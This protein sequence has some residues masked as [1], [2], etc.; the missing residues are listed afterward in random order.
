ML[1]LNNCNKDSSALQ[2]YQYEQGNVIQLNESELD[3]PEISNLLN[4]LLENTSEYMRLYMDEGRFESLKREEQSAEF[5]FQNEMKVTSP[6]LGELKFN[7]ILI[8]LSGDFAGS[9]KTSNMT[10]FIGDTKY[11]PEPIINKTGF[12]LLQKLIVELEKA[13][14]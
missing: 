8:P 14:K 4:Q 11:F 13:K 2:V 7:R 1:S 12:S 10:L 9:E 5:I 3:I 6:R